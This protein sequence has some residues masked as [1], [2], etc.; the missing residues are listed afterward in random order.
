MEEN[1]QELDNFYKKYLKGKEFF[2]KDKERSHDYFKESLLILEDL[3]SKNI[4]IEE[5]SIIDTE[6]ECKKYLAITLEYCIESEVNN[7]NKDIDYSFLLKSI[8]EGTI[9]YIKKYKYGEINFKK[10]INKQTLLHHAIKYG[11]TAFLKHAFKIG[12]NTDIPNND[13]YNLL[14]YACLERDPNMIEFLIDHGADMK[15]NLYFR[16]GKVKVFNFAQSI[17]NAILYKIIFNNNFLNNIDL[18]NNN[19]NIIIGDKILNLKKYLNCD[20]LIGINNL[21]INDLLNALILFLNLMDNTSALTYIEIITE[22]LE[23]NLKIKLGC[24]TSKID[25]ILVN[26]IPFI[27]YPFNLTNSWLI[28]LE[29]KYLI[30][31]LIKN[32]SKLNLYSFKKE[33]INYIWEYYISSQ[34]LPESYIGILVFQWISKIKV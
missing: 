3:R 28:S 29:L 18:K 16:N 26:L 5:K 4:N 21:L 20:E 30:L 22:E 31:N 10:L 13:G 34:L 24:P 7:N 33:L 9:D 23:Y 1:S 6:N 8:K 15:K 11:D 12:A 32:H 2:D 17:D 19:F 14:E 25:I 27:N